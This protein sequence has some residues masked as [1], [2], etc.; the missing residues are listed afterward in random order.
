M[1]GFTRVSAEKK[2]ELDKEKLV[3]KLEQQLKDETALRQE[4]LKR[5]ELLRKQLENVE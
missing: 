1:F 4:S 5:S 3:A 2:A